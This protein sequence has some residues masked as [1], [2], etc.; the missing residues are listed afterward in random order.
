GFDSLTAVELRNRLGVVTGLRLPV[1]CVFD[2]PT[3]TVLA[4]YLHTEMFGEQPVTGGATAAAP[5]RPEA[6][7]K[8]V[9][10]DE[11]IAIIGMSCRFPGGVRTP[12]ALWDLL[13]A[14]GDVISGFPEDRGWDID[15]LYDPDPEKSGTSYVQSGGFLDEVGHFDPAFFGISPREAMAIDPQQRL[16]LETSWE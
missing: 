1:T 3:A 16:L 6:L 14:E 11:P 7:D 10:T 9:A 8:P 2:Y 12:E 15:G 5:K 4:R 13:M